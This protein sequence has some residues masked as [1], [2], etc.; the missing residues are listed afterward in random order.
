MKVNYKINKLLTGMLIFLLATTGISLSSRASE[1]GLLIA[2]NP[3]APT[4]YT[5]EEDGVIDKRWKFTIPAQPGENFDVEVVFTGNSSEKGTISLFYGEVTE[6]QVVPNV[7][8]GADD[9]SGLLDET[10]VAGEEQVRS[11][12]VAAIDGDIVITAVGEGRIVSVTVTKRIP[13]KSGEKATVYTLGDSLVQTYSERYAPQTGWGQTLPNYFDENVNFVNRALGG[14]STGNFIRQGRLNEVLCDILPGDYVLIEF[15]HNDASFGNGDRY[16]SV[17]KYKKNLADTYIK[18]I[19]DRGAT[20]ILV[21]VCNRNAR[22]RVTDDFIASY[23]EYVEAMRQVTEETGTLLVDLNAITVEKFSELNR[24]WGAD[25]CGGIIYNNALAGVYEGEYADGASDGT[26]LQKYG[27]EL[28]AGY[29]AEVLKDMNLTG[30]SEYYVPAESATEVPAVPS[31]IAE[32]VYEGSVSRITWN[33]SE[34]ADFYQI[35]MAKVVPVTSADGTETTY[36]LAGDFEVRGYTTVCDYCYKMADPN[37]NYAYKVVAINEAGQSEASEVFSFGLL[38]E[39]EDNL[40]SSSGET[41]DGE[42]QESSDEVSDGEEVVVDT[43]GV[44]W[45]VLGL[46]VLSVFAF[47]GLLVLISVFFNKKGKQAPREDNSD[48]LP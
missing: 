46:F 43:M 28:V 41:V 7:V 19:R 18:A 9:R 32:R 48:Y 44:A 36:E 15:G 29:I 6:D 23:P 42:T 30:L 24:K 20:P 1:D 13:S 12:E 14:R 16:V 31:G 39:P 22:D 4:T 26:H 33:H 21:T 17:D 40:A 5:F 10:V 35:Q 34:G 27:A 47:V 2:G 37:E 8:E 38:P 3:F 25:V 11:F 45:R